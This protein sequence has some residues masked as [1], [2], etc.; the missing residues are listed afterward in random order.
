MGDRSAIAWTDA[1]W[2]P[3]Q[4]CHKV[5]LGCKHCYMFR[6]KHQYGQEPNVVVRSKPHTFNLPLQL[7]EP[8]RV[9]TCSW[10]DFFIV[11]ADPWHDEAWAIIRRTLHLTYQI[12]TKRIERVAP[13]LPWGRSA[14]WPNVQLV[15]SVEDEARADE[16]IPELLRLNIAV[17]GVSY[18]PALGPIDFACRH[19]LP[20]GRCRG[21]GW[22]TRRPFQVPWPDRRPCEDC[23]AAARDVGLE[24]QPGQYA[25]PGPR[26]D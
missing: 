10:S 21:R 23:I 18:E 14:P 26:L 8:A 9:F 1:T 25:K 5:S 15:V 11:E 16:R 2:N 13:L 4:G 20:C 24:L 12:L 7:K 3:W 17:R 6:E 22:Y 19:W